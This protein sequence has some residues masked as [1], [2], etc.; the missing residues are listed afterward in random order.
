M[1]EFDLKDTILTRLGENYDLHDKYVNRTL[2]K[3]QRTIG[4]DKIYARAEGAYLYDLD[5]KDYLDFLS[6]YSVFNI[7]RNHPTIQKAIRDVLDLDLPNMVQ[8]DCSVLSGLLAEALVKKLGPSRD[9]CFLCNSGTEAVEGAMKF[10][11][12]STK[13]PKILAQE[14][15]YHGLTFGALSITHS[16]NFREDFDPFLPGAGFVKFGDLADLESKLRSRDVAAF[17]FEPVQ[18]KGVKYPSDDYFPAAQELCRKYGTL[19]IADEVQTALGRT[20]KWF[21]FQHWN[22]DPDIVTMA[23]ALSGGYVPCAAIVMRRPIYQGIF[24]RL[25]RCVAHSTTFGRNNLAMACGL[26]SLHV[27]ENEHLVEN[28]ALR[29]EQL[30]SKLRDLQEKYDVINYIRENFLRPH[31]PGQLF[32]VTPEYL[33]KLP[34]GTTKG[35]L[36]VKREPFETAPFL[37]PANAGQEI[38][39]SADASGVQHAN[40]DERVLAFAVYDVDIAVARA[41]PAAKTEGSK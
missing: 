25:D 34:K 6:G 35:P 3:V 10:A 9:A 2:V 30:M 8:M 28:A 5:G 12:A 1:S 23:K 22:L 26:A 38:E 16:G 29:G 41:G 19:F 40:G 17:I 20:G 27:T 7:G 13:R 39:F 4:F 15:S 14:G 36:A 24:S 21:G 31:N 32:E 37:I 11:R 33:A 18:G